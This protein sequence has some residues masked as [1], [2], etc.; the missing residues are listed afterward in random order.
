MKWLPILGILALVGVISNAISSNKGAVTAGNDQV[1]C[2]SLLVWL[3]AVY[4]CFHAWSNAPRIIFWSLVFITLLHIV[5]RI[6]TRSGWKAII[7]IAY[8]L[9]VLTYACRLAKIL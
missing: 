2:W 9:L 1:G 3:I 7:S 8:W 6:Q 4:T 5:S